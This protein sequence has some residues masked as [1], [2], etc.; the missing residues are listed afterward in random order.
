MFVIFDTKVQAYMAPSFM[1]SEGQMRRAIY[2]A[3]KD[4]NTD[5]SKYPEDFI[6]YMVGEYDDQTAKVENN[7]PVTVGSVLQIAL[8]ELKQEKK[9]E[10]LYNAALKGGEDE[11]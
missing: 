4:Q 7:P 6:V 9:A 8:A 2:Q 1:Q 10:M 5:L 3:S 11:E